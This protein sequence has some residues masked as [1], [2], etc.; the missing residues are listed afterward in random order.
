MAVGDD[1]V[2]EHAVQFAAQATDEGRQAPA[3]FQLPALRDRGAAGVS[4]KTETAHSPTRTRVRVPEDSRQ[5]VDSRDTAMRSACLPRGSP[6]GAY[7]TSCSGAT[8]MLAPASSRGSRA[9]RGSSGSQPSIHCFTFMARDFDKQRTH[10]DRPAGVRQS[11]NPEATLRL[12]QTTKTCG[13][14]IAIRSIA[15]PSAYR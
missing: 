7:C 4:G 13:L 15:R 5:Q 1:D 14:W 12:F 9:L 10:R 3:R 6:T 11:G 8:S 2:G